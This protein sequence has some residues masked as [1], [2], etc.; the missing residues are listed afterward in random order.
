MTRQ[1]QAV[2]AELERIDDF[3]SAQQI[4]EDLG[5]A[6]NRVGLATV[7]RNLQALSEAGELDV[8]RAQDGENLYRK[9]TVRTHHHHLVCR[10]C[11]HTEDIEPQGMEAW[12]ASVA[13]AH[14]YTAIEH[15]VE[16]FGLC[17]G[18]TQELRSATAP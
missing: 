16:V 14:G 7:Y 9:C 8:L 18:C 6:G 5:T 13:A 1:R 3:R 4:F 12:V 11:G 17:A 10:R 15:S 2:L